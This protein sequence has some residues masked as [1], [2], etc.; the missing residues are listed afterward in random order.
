MARIAAWIAAMVMA[1]A[2]AGCRST[3][4]DT[5]DDLGIGTAIDGPTT[6]TAQEC[7]PWIEPAWTGDA[8]ERYTVVERSGPARVMVIAREP[9]QA[10]GHWTI[11]RRFEGDAQPLEVTRLRLAPDGGLTLAGASNV[12]RGVRV[13][14]DPPP[15]AIPARLQRGV[16]DHAEMSIRLP[17]LDA[18][19]RLRE[20]GRAERTLT[21]LGERLVRLGERETPAAHVREVFTSRLSAATAVRITDRWYVRG[22]GLIAERWTE[23]VRALGVVVESSGR[24]MRAT[25]AGSGAGYPTD[26]APR[27]RGE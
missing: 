13:V 19:G 3:P 2:I 10:P 26:S 4:R 8:T 24:A 15:T 17:R 27:R 9:G 18:P 25:G 22:R 12:E 5:P 11:T 16:P 23:E 14:L 20:Q 1:A 7:A 21:F 6:L